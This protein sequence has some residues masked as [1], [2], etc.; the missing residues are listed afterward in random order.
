[1]SIFRRLSCTT[2]LVLA[3][4]FCTLPAFA[5]E[6]MWTFDN[7]PVDAIRDTY[8]FEITPEWLDH[9][10]LA[11]VRFNDGGSG[12]FVSPRG[13][14]VTNHHV[15]V[16]QLQ[17]MST[18]AKDYVADGFYAKNA[19]EEIA[20][21]DLELNVTE[22]MENVTARV[23][24]AVK[25]GMSSQEALRARKAEMALI[26]SE[27]L[28]QTGLRSDVVTLYQGGEYWLY[29]YR[30]YTDVRL[31]MAPE[32][33]AAFFGG[34]W[35][36]F[37]FPRYNLDFAFFRVYQDGKPLQPSHW[38]GWSTDGP[39]EN[40]LVFI[41]GNPGRTSR[42]RTMR[43]LE[44]FRDNSYPRRLRQIDRTLQLLSEYRAQ[45]D[46]EARR[47]GVLYFSYSNARKAYGGMLKALENEKLMAWK[48]E[49]EWNLR[50]AVMDDPEMQK[51]YGGAWGRVAGIYD[52]HSDR[53][54]TIA[55]RGLVNG[56][57]AGRLIRAA[58]DITR[59]VHEIQLPDADRLDGYH[60]TELEEKLFYLYSPAPIYQDLES[61]LLANTLKLIL[62]ELDPDDPMSRI[63]AGL[64]DLDEAAKGLV[65]K[66]GLADV[67]NRRTLIEGG[68]EAVAASKDPMIV[69]TRQAAPLLREDVEWQRRE[70]ES[71]LTPA[72]E[73]IA[74]ARFAVLG[75]N[76]YPDATFTLRLSYGQAKGYP[77]NGTLAPFK[78]TLYGMFNRALAFGNTGDFLL[79]QRFWER[80]EKLNLS[81]P[82]NFVSSLDTIGGNSGSPVINSRLE[83]VGINFDRNI[84]GL[85]N[86]F[87]NDPV[88]NR[89][90][91]VHSAVVLEALRKLY[92]AGLLADELVPP[93]TDKR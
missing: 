91:A 61:L 58:L 17:K 73:Q 51:A 71:V 77:M 23:L 2:G 54:R 93:T 32:K 45:G 16:G 10:R 8:G 7:P 1:M 69:F 38:F 29:R 44:F 82:V 40:E 20:C 88:H 28:E 26:R 68:A 12:S 21:A 74:R 30:K 50:R 81:T 89:C 41:S 76:A 78:T 53:L 35:D 87:L 80:E 22:S 34:D 90:V 59:Y 5:D 3:A 19:A 62:E 55:V 79:P 92:D 64:G 18:E 9:V 15:A 46:E 11:S 72:G 4:L 25:D 43:A 42:L 52:D 37:T 83:Q 14:V 36:N 67:N 13:L 65:T 27:S 56:R 63:I 84:E 49:A 33:Q 57:G 39:A 48:G 66:T 24:G 47:G 75:K 31:V 6:G 85:S 60:E 70:V 86:S